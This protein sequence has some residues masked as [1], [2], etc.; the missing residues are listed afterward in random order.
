MSTPTPSSS[1]SSTKVD[2]SRSSQNVWLV[3]VPKYLAECWQKADASGIVGTLRIPMNI[4]SKNVQFQLSE[5]LSMQ[6]EASGS[7]TPQEHKMFMSDVAARLSM[8]LFSETAP[9]E[10]EASE[11]LTNERIAFEGRITKR[12]DCRPV[13]DNNYMTMKR[14]AFE[15]Q[16]Q[17]GR[18]VKQIT[19]LHTNFKPVSDHPMNAEP[20]RR[21]KEEGKRVRG[22]KEEVLETLFTAFEKHQFY[23]LKD[24]VHIS[25][26]PVVHL[27]SI[28]RDVCNYNTKN[29]HKNMYELKPE[30]RHYASKEDPDAEMKST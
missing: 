15:L 20:E 21:R 17:P 18:Q 25:K 1:T 2:M 13:Q 29:P 3:K 24:L 27:K 14:K 22:T 28:L 10:E 9:D 23:S 4:H 5:Q 19:T 6:K 11:E 8:G 16:M 7:V 26:Q 12:A 30:Y